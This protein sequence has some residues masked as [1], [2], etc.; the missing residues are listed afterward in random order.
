MNNLYIYLYSCFFVKE[1]V[2]FM[3]IENSNQGQDGMIHDTPYG[4]I[5]SY[6]GDTGTYGVVETGGNAG[7]GH[8]GLTANTWVDIRTTT[9]D[10]NGRYMSMCLNNLKDH[11]GSIN[12]MYRDSKGNITVGINNNWFC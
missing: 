5:H 1:E 9:K 12:T 11:E 2:M 6:D 7:G 3:G 8:T 4:T 10:Y